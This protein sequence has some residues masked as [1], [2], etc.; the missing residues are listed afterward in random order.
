MILVPQG[1]KAL[2]QMARQVGVDLRG[3]SLNLDGGCDAARHR[4]CM[5][6]TGLI[7]NITKHPRQRRFNAAIHA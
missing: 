6:H 4:K 5:F 1:L 7:P 3:T 2:E